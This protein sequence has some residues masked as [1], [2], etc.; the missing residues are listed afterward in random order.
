[1]SDVSDL[2]ECADCLCLASRRA[3]RALSRSFERRLRP[4]GLRIG[5]FSALTALILKGAMTVGAL[6]DFLGVERTTLTR[7]LRLIEAKGWVTIEAGADARS[8]VVAVTP[9]G[10]KTVEAAV[11]S[12]RA[13]QHAAAATIGAAGVASLHRLAAKPLA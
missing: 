6:A 13:A 5:Q 3:A 9:A 1:M 4:H 10:R 12:W 8:R 7:N 11:P 2:M